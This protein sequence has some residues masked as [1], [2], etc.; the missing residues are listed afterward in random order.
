MTITIGLVARVALDQL[1]AVVRDRLPS[2][3]EADQAR[4]Q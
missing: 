4:T 3:V 1:E 2:Q